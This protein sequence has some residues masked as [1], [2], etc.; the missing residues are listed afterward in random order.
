MS[1]D[2]DV[3][4]QKQVREDGFARWWLFV[5]D[6]ALVLWVVRVPLFSFLVAILL[7]RLTQTQDVLLDLA[8]R[9]QLGWVDTYWYG[10]GSASL[11]EAIKVSFF[12][13][14]SIPLYVV[15]VFFMWAMPAHYMARLALD[16]DGRYNAWARARENDGHYCIRYFEI[17][18]PRI[19]GAGCFAILFFAV[20]FAQPPSVD[21]A[22]VQALF[23]EQP[24]LAGFLG[25]AALFFLSYAVLRR[26][27]IER[28]EGY[29]AA[30]A[31]GTDHARFR[32]ESPARDLSRRWF[33]IACVVLV[34]LVFTELATGVVVDL[35]GG[36][37]P[38]YS[39]VVLAW[40]LPVVLGGWIPLFGWLGV[41]GRRWRCPLIFL[42]MFVFTVGGIWL[43]DLHH[44]RRS[45]VPPTGESQSHQT[46]TSGNRPQLNDALAVW[47]KANDCYHPDNPLDV[48]GC[49]RPIII[50]AAGG[51]SRAA[52][53]TASTIGRLLDSDDLA[54]G[55][56][57]TTTRQR[58][59]PANHKPFDSGRQA[60][61]GEGQE[62]PDSSGMRARI[63][64][65]SSVSGSSVGALM[66][67]N[68]M[69]VVHDRGETKHPCATD[70]GASR[71][72]GGSVGNWQDCLEALTAGDFLSPTVV[73]MA[74][75]DPLQPLM[76]GAW[77]LLT[78]RAA[79]TDRGSM[80]EDS[81]RTWV[82]DVL[83]PQAQAR[84]AGADGGGDRCLGSLDC[85]FLSL[86]DA[87]LKLGVDVQ[88]GDW[89]PLV[90][91][92][93]ASAA[94]GRRIMTSPLSPRFSLTEGQ[95]CPAERKL[96]GNGT[97]CLLFSQTLDLYDDLFADNRPPPEDQKS[98]TE[99]FKKLAPQSVN[100]AK[101]E[102][103]ISIATAASNSARFPLISPPGAVRNKT[104]Q[105]VDRILDGG[106]VEAVGATTAL[107]L[108]EALQAIAP[109]LYPF[110][111]VITN[112]PQ[113]GTIVLPAHCPIPQTASAAVAQ[114]RDIQKF[115]T[116]TG[117]DG[118]A[119]ASAT[120]LL[121]GD[122]VGS[123]IGTSGC[124]IAPDIREA[125]WLL[126]LTGPL[127]GVANARTSR[128]LMAA[129][130][131][132]FLLDGHAQPGTALD[133]RGRNFC[134]MAH[135]RVWPTSQ[136]HE[137]SR[138]EFL[139]EQFRKE[140]GAGT[141]CESA[142]GEKPADVPMNEPVSA[143]SMS[144]WLSRP[145]Q[146]HLRRQLESH[147]GSSRSCPDEPARKRN[148]GNSNDIAIAQVW[149]A[150]L[151]KNRDISTAIASTPASALRQ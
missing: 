41:L 67:V 106:Y 72:F 4:A 61:P 105:V 143:V 146:I 111:L 35:F 26:W 40:A 117:G 130:R 112:D 16:F 56:N 114:W 96:N 90:F 51:A 57:A 142:G 46:L 28:R 122:H 127:K 8:Q 58:D 150:V 104:A 139:K 107:E 108:V 100:R 120:C 128:G 85:P 87:T 17:W 115:R 6:A 42:F 37:T 39:L 113:D 133:S 64:A 63:F 44:V 74:F 119:Q 7:C 118:Q 149:Q 102:H 47:M 91:S 83:D 81:W 29:A 65:I 59:T 12:G 31:A 19:I 123:A 134:N 95:T 137:A 76:A 48:S 79:G 10:D 55:R 50:A 18:V 135:I 14:L 49:P 126:D 62:Y 32:R 23:Y 82:G 9:L 147:S 54:R 145:V 1:V 86:Y 78:G 94:T 68:A 27:L 77:H 15:W 138:R 93:G 2:F 88:P 5:V 52:F 109:G 30:A 132:R 11:D 89:L 33:G 99:I 70:S 121:D 84:A 80:L 71:W 92:N 13:L 151:Q 3:P 69:A 124:A 21:D 36:N 97:E 141:E 34:F 103:D 144:W 73:F 60:I 24:V 38:L 129:A 25:V 131:T 66:A 148:P 53:F 45:P 43:G 125:H 98:K 101:E 136:D 116:Q 140:L 110:V 75:R 20:I 22:Q